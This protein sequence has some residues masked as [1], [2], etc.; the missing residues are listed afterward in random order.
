[1]DRQFSCSV[2][3]SSAEFFVRRC[4]WV[5]G[6]SGLEG[7]KVSYLKHMIERWLHLRGMYLKAGNGG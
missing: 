6:V 7:S 1:M 2:I 3:Q 4:L 5:G